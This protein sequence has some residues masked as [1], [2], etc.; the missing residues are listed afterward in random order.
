MNVSSGLLKASSGNV[1][2]RQ[3]ATLTD[4]AL[5]PRY[6]RLFNVISHNGQAPRLV[7]VR[8]DGTILLRMHIST[9]SLCLLRRWY[10][11]RQRTRVHLLAAGW[12][13]VNAPAGSRLCAS[14]MARAS[15]MSV[16]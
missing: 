5:R 2:T 13:P 16:A 14:E 10:L 6:K 9:L 8:P 15:S 7:E 3:L 12:H 4:T 11:Q 1:G